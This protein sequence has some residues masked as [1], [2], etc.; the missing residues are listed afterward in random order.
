MGYIQFSPFCHRSCLLHGDYVSRHCQCCQCRELGYSLSR[1]ITILAP[2]YSQCGRL[3]PPGFF[4]FRQG[5]LASGKKRVSTN[6][7]CRARAG[8]WPGHEPYTRA[9]GNHSEMEGALSKHVRTAHAPQ[10]WTPP[11]ITLNVRTLPPDVGTLPLFASSRAFWSW[12]TCAFKID[13]SLL[14]VVSYLSAELLKQPPIIALT[15]YVKS[16]DYCSDKAF[17]STMN[18]VAGPVPSDRI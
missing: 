14:E 3:Q 10:N 17:R 7:P 16:L 8:S 11:R 2:G 15:R 4:K 13:T 1:R 6:P 12:S 9:T 18:G 5:S